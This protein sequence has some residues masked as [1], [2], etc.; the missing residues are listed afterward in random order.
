MMSLDVGTQLG[1]QEAFCF[2]LQHY[3]SC[4]TLGG[5]A[6]V[7][8]KKQ[9]HAGRTLPVPFAGGSHWLGVFTDQFCSSR[10]WKELQE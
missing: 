7:K 6:Q 10:V 4:S 9:E 5:V 8:Q 2:S 3:L 1:E